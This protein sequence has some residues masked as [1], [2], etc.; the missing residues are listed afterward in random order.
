MPENLVARRD[1]RAGLDATR[2][3][4]ADDEQ[5]RDHV[6]VLDSPHATCAAQAG[7]HL[8]R[9]HQPLVAVAQLADTAHELSGW[10]PVA[11][12]GEPRLDHHCGDAVC[13]GNAL[14]NV[15]LE[16]PQ[17]VLDV[18]GFLHPGRDVL[19]IGIGRLDDAAGPG[20]QV[21][22]AAAVVAAH[23]LA[24]DRLA[25]EGRAEGDDVATL[26]VAQGDEGGR[27]CGFRARDLEAETG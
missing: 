8:V 23:D 1:A 26:R 2:E 21:A 6:V 13:G 18:L 14:G 15:V 12:L 5:V 25:V 4:L 16:V 17:A 11:A 10:N 20:L 24:G 9:D 27:L 7:E 19:A 22:I 3:V